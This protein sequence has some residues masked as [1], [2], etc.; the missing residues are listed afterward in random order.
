[1]KKMIPVVHSHK[2]RNIMLSIFTALSLSSIVIF[3]KK[4][5]K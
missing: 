3:L 4:R 1:M 2:N 5:G